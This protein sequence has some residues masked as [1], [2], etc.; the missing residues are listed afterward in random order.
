[1]TFLQLFPQLTVIITTVNFHPQGDLFLPT[2]W[3]DTEVH[4]SDRRLEL[5]CYGSIAILVSC[6]YLRKIATQV[7]GVVRQSTFVL[8]SLITR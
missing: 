8:T 4:C 3:C 7:L 2:Q 6:K 1:M 5:V